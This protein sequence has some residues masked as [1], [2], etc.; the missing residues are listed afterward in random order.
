VPK[1]LLSDQAGHLGS[2]LATLGRNLLP[3]WSILLYLAAKLCRAKKN[4]KVTKLAMR[5]MKRTVLRRFPTDLL[6]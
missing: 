5:D 3:T 1:E 4:Y 2:I 6:T